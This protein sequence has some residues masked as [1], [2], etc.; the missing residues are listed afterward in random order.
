[1]G[2]SVTSRYQKDWDA[3]E[4]EVPPDSVVGKRASAASTRADANWSTESACAKFH[5]HYSLLVQAAE[6]SPT[7]T[8]QECGIHPVPAESGPIS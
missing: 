7:H 1:M 2:G 8:V 5:L 3:N 6:A 4:K